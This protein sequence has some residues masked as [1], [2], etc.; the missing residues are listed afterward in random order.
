MDFTGLIIGVVILLVLIALGVHIGIS[1]AV[2]GGVGLLFIL[3]PEQATSMLTTS[4]YYV[5]ERWTYVVIPL[6]I[7]MGLLSARGG[8]SKNLYT[9]LNYWLGRIR[10]GLGIATVAACTVF[11]TVCGS[12][13]VT[14]SV[15]AQVSAPEMRK[16]GYSKE[17]AY[18]ICTSAGMIG[19]LIPPSIFAVVWAILTNESVGRLLLAGLGPGILMAIVFSV[20]ILMMG[21]F[22]PSDVGGTQ[23]VTATW[24]QRFASLKL[25]W[26]ILV[27][28][29][30][31]IGGIFGGV[32]SATEA[33]AVAA[34]VVLIII[35][36][37]PSENRW[38]KVKSGFI[39]TASTSAMIFLIL[40]GASIFSR[41]LVLTGVTTWLMEVILS[42]N[43]SAMG[44]IILYTV[45]LLIL[46]CFLDGISI[47]SITIPVIYPTVKAMGIDPIWFGMVA[48]VAIHIGL[49]TPPFGL[50]AFAVKAVAERDVSL[51]AIFKGVMP[52]LLMSFAVL[53]IVIAIP[54]V[55]TVFPSF[56]MQ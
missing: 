5:G 52:F 23:A 31:L 1:L 40:G 55:S 9:G 12:A 35:L 43:L 33:G 18:G 28:A 15:F 4:L 51:E 42:W 3:G 41:F 56:M 44:F 25:L 27:V 49:I 26:P 45:V 16:H 47:M 19:M 39:E 22:K 7:F 20:G 14:A 11:G 32:F 10:G 46:G 29:A 17:L 24:R 30:T 50:N 8:I 37:T 6:F 36:A 34:L 54:W 2:A 13:M 38:Q 21:K 48:I 53:I